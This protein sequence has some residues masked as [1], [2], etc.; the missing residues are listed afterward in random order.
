MRPRLQEKYENEVLP[1]FKQNLGRENRMDVPRLEKVVVNM[2]VGSAITEKKHIEE[3]VEALSQ[4]T[5]QKPQVT[6][7]RKSIAGFKLREGTWS[8]TGTGG[9]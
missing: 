3:S 2:G 1:A 7:A 8:P 6:I 9:S 5:G 4:I